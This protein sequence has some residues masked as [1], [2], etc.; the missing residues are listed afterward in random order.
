[1]K[2]IKRRIY[3]LYYIKKHGHDKT[4]RQ[5]YITHTHRRG[6]GGGFW[7]FRITIGL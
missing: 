4:I 7:R 1:M 3:I 6:G 2:K 5:N